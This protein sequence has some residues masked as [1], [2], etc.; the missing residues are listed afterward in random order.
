M[1]A[2]FK[3][4]GLRIGTQNFPL[5]GPWNTLSKSE[6]SGFAGRYALDALRTRRPF[7]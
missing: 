1:L 6:Q 5:V 4:C 7:G 3:E 2:P